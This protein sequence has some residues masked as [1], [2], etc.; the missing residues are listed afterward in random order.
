MKKLLI[1]LV[2]ILWASVAA[3]APFLA[4]DPPANSAITGSQI[5][6]DGAWETKIDVPGCTDKMPGCVWT[7]AEN[8]QHFIFRDLA[9]LPDGNHVIRARFHTDVR[10]GEISD[11]FVFNN[12]PPGKPL[13][14]LIP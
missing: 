4:S 9:G 6:M 2:I 11:P 3:S 8:K 1:C 10:A 5:E 14:R 12:Q 7:D 13:L